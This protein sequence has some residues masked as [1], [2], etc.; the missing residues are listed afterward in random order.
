MNVVDNQ[1]IILSG[2]G[3]YLVV[4]LVIGVY[5]ARRTGSP[6]DFVVAG[7]ALPLWLCSATVM[8][9]WIGGGTMM[10]ASGESYRGGVLAVIADPFGASVGLILVGLLV[11]RIVRRLKLLTLVD[12]I[13]GRYGSVAA[14]FTALA[15]VFSNVGWAGALMVAFGFVFN[16]LTGM[17]L[18]AGIVIGGLIVLTY[19]TIGGMWAVALTDFVQLAVIIVG[20]VILLVVVVADLGGPAAALAA[21]PDGKLRMLPLEDTANSWLNYMRA[22]FIIGIAN[23]CSQSL[24]QRGLSAKT[25]SVAQNS[26]YIAGVGYLIIGSIPVLLGIFASVLMPDL[27][28][29]ET[30]IPTLAM[31]Y[32][33]PV[34]MSIFVGALLAAIMSSADSALLAVASVVSINVL[35]KIWPSTGNRRLLTARL[36]IPIAGIVAAVIALKTQ[37]IYEVILAVNTVFLAAIVVPFMAGIWWRKANRTGGLSAMGTGLLI[38]GASSWFVPE[39]PGDL[40]GMFASAI[41]LLV[42]TPMS[43]QTDPPQPLMS[44]DGQPVKLDNRLGVLRN[45]PS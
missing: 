31:T 21:V 40:L 8:A 30:V 36:T 41:A 33:Q 39:W 42:V 25:E 15:L 35:P 22:W 38:W 1:L 14:M 16:S 32:L 43:Q 24:I 10:G 29:K 44:S 2:V 6:E 34:L 20:L 5:A 12:F 23:L 7:R 18:E 17:S 19:T 13:E 37:A 28:D 4:M 26:F 45:T 9:T 11:I 27:A 3:V